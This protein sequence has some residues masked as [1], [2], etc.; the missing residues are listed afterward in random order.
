MS[1][2]THGDPLVTTITV[3]LYFLIDHNNVNNKLDQ[4]YHYYTWEQM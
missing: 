1:L 2:H 3:T 4:A